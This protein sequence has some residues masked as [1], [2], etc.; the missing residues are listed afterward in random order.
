MQPQCERRW[1][2]RN[3]LQNQMEEGLV[4][5]AGGRQQG[6]GGQLGEPREKLRRVMKERKVQVHR[7]RRGHVIAGARVSGRVSWRPPHTHIQ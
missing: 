6:K 2:S 1:Y 4:S 5:G 7:N 3:F